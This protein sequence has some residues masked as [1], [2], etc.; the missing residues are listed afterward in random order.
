MKTLLERLLDWVANQHDD[1]ESTMD[2]VDDEFRTVDA[3]VIGM[4]SGTILT[5]LAMWWLWGVIF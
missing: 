3:I 4:L 2:E 5:L 1:L